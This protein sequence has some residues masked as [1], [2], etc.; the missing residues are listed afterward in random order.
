[1]AGTKKKKRRRS[2]HRGDP[3][4]A[5]IAA[6]REEARRQAR[7]ERRLAAIAAEKRERRR[8]VFRRVTTWTLGGVALAALALFLFRSAP[9]IDGV[10]TPDEQEA[11]ALAAGETFDYGTP[12]PTSGP[13]LESDP[14]CGVFAE[15]ISAEDA[16][17]AL[18]HGAVVIWHSPDLGEADV[19]ELAALAADAETYVV[20]SP[21]ASLDSPIVATAWNRLLDYDTPADAAEFIETYRKRGP[22]SADCPVS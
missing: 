10:V 15:E 12:A 2:R 7:E 6:R 20:V 14:S 18:Y 1:M 13:Y 19:A 5:E 8:K 22:G 17:T 9:E 3:N 11:V 4:R 16:V 21:N